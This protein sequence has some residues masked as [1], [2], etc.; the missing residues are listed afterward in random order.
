MRHNK[1][2]IRTKFKRFH[3]DLSKYASFNLKHKICNI[4]DYNEL[5]A[6]HTIKN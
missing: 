2:V 1:L 6:Q 4:V 5:L 3:F